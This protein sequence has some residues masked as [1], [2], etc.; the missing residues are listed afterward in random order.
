MTLDT[1]TVRPGLEKSTY[2]IRHAECL[3]LQDLCRDAFGFET[4]GQIRT[5]EDF[6]KVH[7]RFGKSHPDLM[8]RLSY[9]FRAGQRFGDMLSAWERG[10]IATVGEV[11]RADGHGLRDEFRISGPELETM[12]DLVRTVPGVLGERMLG[13]GDKGASGALVL[14]ESEEEVRRAVTAG[15]PRSHPDY[16]D[17]FAIHS[18]R[19]VDGITE[20]PGW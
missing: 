15:Y 2:R 10:D 5:E 16:A 11:F 6:G 18:C 3:Q 17:R 8:E 1:G 4:V 9:L 13:G 12:C 14:A 20:L 7:A 19:M